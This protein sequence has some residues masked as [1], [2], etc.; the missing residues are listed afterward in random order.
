M[1]DQ[2]R[3]M[4]QYAVGQQHP[5]RFCVRSPDQ[6]D[7]RYVEVNAPYAVVGRGQGVDLFLDGDIVGF[8]H[9]YLQV[10][11]N[12]VCCIDLFSLN[13]ISW[14]GPPTAPWLSA[15]HRLRIGNHWVQLQEDE[16][17]ADDLTSPLDFKPRED[18][19]IEYGTLPTVDLQLLNTP[20]KGAVWPINRVITLLGRDERCRITIA[21][22]RISKVHCSLLLLPTGLW[23]V[24]LLGKGGVKLN[25]YEC[26]CGYLAQ[27]C[28][29]QV[30]EYIITARY[31]D[32]VVPSP[33]AGSLSGASSSGAIRG[34]GGGGGNAGT[35]S[36]RIN[37]VFKV[38]TVSDTVIVIPM[39]D[40]SD[41]SYKEIHLDAGRITELFTQH[42]YRNVVVDFSVRPFVGSII[43]DALVGFC[44]TAKGRA[45]FCEVSPEMKSSFEEMKLTT[46]W[47]M[48]PTRPEALQAIYMT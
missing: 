31:P 40:L 43:I 47:P 16:W 36:T 37:K 23:V 41:F 26:R 38:E 3:A 8:R 28:E 46:L 4:L 12:R 13:G 1:D 27:G 5:L 45:A 21:D 44:R 11:G 29:L 20:A 34:A 42:G 35:F 2:I 10:I 18:Q 7:P 25:G 22:E 14:D 17:T 19:R 6:P 48:Y 32:A 9:A 30:G 39:G 33:S 24:D 15:A